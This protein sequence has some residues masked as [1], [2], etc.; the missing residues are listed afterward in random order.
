[1]RG[2]NRKREKGRE[3]LDAIL[4]ALAEHGPM[5]TPELINVAGIAK[6]SIDGGNIFTFNEM[7]REEKSTTRLR[8]TK[9]QDKLGVWS[10]RTKQSS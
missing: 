6:G 1:M 5:T 2:R 4:K 7:L 8:F 10:I 3:N 9:E